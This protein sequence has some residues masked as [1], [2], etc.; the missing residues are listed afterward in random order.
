MASIFRG[1]STLMDSGML[2]R[3][4]VIPESEEPTNWISNGSRGVSEG[5]GHEL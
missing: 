2:I 3:F 5:L 4:V 1:I